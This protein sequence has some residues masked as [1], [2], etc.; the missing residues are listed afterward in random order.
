MVVG[1]TN[2]R[3]YQVIGAVVLLLVLAATYAYAGLGVLN[4]AVKACKNFCPL[5]NSEYDTVKDGDCYCLTTN[6]QIDV[7]NNRMIKVVASINAGK[8]RNVE[9]VSPI[10]QDVQ[11]QIAQQLQ[12]QIA[13]QQNARTQ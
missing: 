11:Q 2:N 10:P 12:Q 5:A 3:L 7:Q 13:Q 1:R 8:V 9:I 6:S 4:P